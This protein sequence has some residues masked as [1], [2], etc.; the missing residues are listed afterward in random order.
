MTGYKQRL[1]VGQMEK[2]R[3]PVRYEM[4]YA[5][6][7]ADGKRYAGSVTKRFPHGII[8][9]SDGTPQTVSVRYL[10]MMP[11]INAPDG[12]THVLSGVLLLGPA[13]LLF[14]FGIR[15]TV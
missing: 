12:E 14:W 5:F 13:A 4:R 11:H 2:T 15:K 8:A 10:P 3:D 9:S 1:Y 6:T 7:A